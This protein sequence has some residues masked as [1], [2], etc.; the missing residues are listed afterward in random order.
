MGFLF[1]QGAFQLQAGTTVWTTSTIRARLVLSSAGVADIDADVMT[2]IGSTD[3]SAFIAVTS[4][5]GPTLDDVNDHVKYSSA[6][7]AFVSVAAIGACNR[8]VFY[9]F[10]T[11]DADSVPIACVDITEVTPNTGNV[12]VTCPA[13]GWWYTQQHA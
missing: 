7:L 10:V 3:A 9:R 5:V 4:P 12:T 11:N 2:G 13:L 6:D 8:V 1:N